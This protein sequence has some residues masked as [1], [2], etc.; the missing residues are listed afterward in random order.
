MILSVD[1]NVLVYI[2]SAHPKYGS[3]SLEN[4]RRLGQEYTLAICY[5]VFAELLAFVED[6]E[7][8]ERFLH[9][10]DIQWRHPTKNAFR[11]SAEKWNIYNKRRK[12]LCSSCGKNLKLTCPYCN[13]DIKVKQHIISDFIIGAFSQ[14]DCG[15]IITH[16]KGFY[17]NYF[18]DLR[19][20]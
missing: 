19:L 11:L 8:L 12:M 17:K 6:E 14:V 3:E 9:D 10:V 15:G 13:T 2:L 7:M 20:Y 1:T 16:D 18:P 4:V 5:V